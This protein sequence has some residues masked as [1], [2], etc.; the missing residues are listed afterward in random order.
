[1]TFKQTRQ[2]TMSTATLLL[3]ADDLWNLPHDGSLHE[4]V[5]GELLTMSPPGFEHGVVG[6]NLNASMHHHA[7]A[8]KLGKVVAAET[9]F[10]I[11]RDPDTVRA[12]DVAFVGNA[13]L[14]QFGIPKKY[15]P[16][17]PDVAVEVISPSD[18]YVEVDEKVEQWLNAGAMAVWVLNPRRKSVTVHV[19]G[20]NPVILKGAD[21][22][23]GGVAFPGFSILVAEIFS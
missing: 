15:F 16:V 5:R 19:Q 18:I 11:E 3:T 23:S 8:N 1:M 14:Q 12:P 20:Q 10:L 2:T 9:G 7:T 21:I 6:N 22:L 13:K 17:A 4:L